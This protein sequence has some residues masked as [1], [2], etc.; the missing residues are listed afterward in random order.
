MSGSHKRTVLSI[1]PVA[2]NF[3][4][5]DQLATNIQLVWPFKACTGVP[6]SVSNILAVLSPLPVT[7]LEEDDAANEVVNIASP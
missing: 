2:I 6:V 5:G 3:S 1:D 4:S 7:I